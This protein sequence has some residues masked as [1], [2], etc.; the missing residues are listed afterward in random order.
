MNWIKENKFLTGFF[1]VMLVSLG[2]LGYLLFAA[3]GKHDEATANYTKQA[4]ELT[5][6]QSLPVSPSQKNLDALVA[7]KKAAVEVVASF[8][9]SLAAK[10]IPAGPLTP[11][12][13]QDKLKAT[14]TA[15]F[16]AAAQAGTVLPPKFFLG[17][18]SYATQ[19][20]Q[21]AAATPLG[22]QLKAIEWVLTQL[23]VNH[24]AELGAEGKDPIKRDLLP[25]ES[26]KVDEE[27]AKKKGGPP[28]ELKTKPLV[29]FHP[30]EIK[31]V[32]TQK[33]LG[34][35]LNALVGPKAP[36]FFIP[37]VITVKNEKTSLPKA[38]AN[39]VPVP[40]QEKKSTGY[41]LGD[42]KLQVTLVIDMV[43]FAG[44]SLPAVK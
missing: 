1:A 26:G 5:R 23:F 33:A 38:D 19:T 37:R 43:D 40:D 30:F 39:P 2:V 36:Q 18:D 28:G 13:F 4:S 32:C 6:L 9:A 20:P 15:I 17:F 8:Q 35:V 34:E 11:E 44:P 3:M 21:G 10:S 22:R 14:K 7:Q 12:Q 29:S 41:V 42:E 24:V 27:P 25:E 31:M 16:E